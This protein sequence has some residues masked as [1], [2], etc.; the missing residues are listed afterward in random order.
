MTDYWNHN[1]A[2]HPELLAAV[3][4]HQAT[5]LDIGCGDGLLLQKMADTAQSVTGID[6]DAKA[7]IQARS[8]LADT[9]NA[10]VILGDFLTSPELTGQCFDLITCVATLHHCPLA[11]ALEKMRDL[12]TPG[13]QLRVVGLAA[14]KTIVDWLISGALVIPVRV[15]SMLHREA[16]Y[17]GMTTTRPKESLDEIRDVATTL[18][19]RCRIRRRLYYRYTLNWTKPCP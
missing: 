3:P 11:P 18:L 4:G 5:V 6:T 17:P 8:R 9:P 12:L 19:P 15:M 1:I 13:G 10:E 16:Q 2:Y 14:N 7:V